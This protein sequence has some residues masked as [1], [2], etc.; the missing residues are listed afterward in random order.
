MK[1]LSVFVMRLTTLFGVLC[2][3]NVSGCCSTTESDTDLVVEYEE[4]PATSS[5]GEGEERSLSDSNTVNQDQDS[6]SIL[7]GD[8]LLEPE[9]PQLDMPPLFVHVTC[10]VNMK[11]CHGSV[12]IQTLPTCLGEFLFPV[13]LIMKEF[14][15]FFFGKLM[16]IPVL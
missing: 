7:E 11:S 10:S 5:H 6:F 9:G 4:H 3:E 1:Y 16:L 13:S 15:F 2:T 8:S 14:F 12:P